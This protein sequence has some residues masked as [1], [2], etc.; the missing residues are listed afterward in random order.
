MEQSQFNHSIEKLLIQFK[1]QSLVE[2]FIC[3]SLIC[4]FPIPLSAFIMFIFP[5][6]LQDY[7][8]FIDLNLFPPDFKDLENLSL[9]FKFIDSSE[10]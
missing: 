8:I 3:L 9:M 4:Y 5:D 1:F 7:S 10:S 6:P 2:E